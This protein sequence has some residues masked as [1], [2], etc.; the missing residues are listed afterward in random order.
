MV[1]CRV[2]AV[3]EPAAPPSP[4][5]ASDDRWRALHDEARALA[6]TSAPE[7]VLRAREAVGVAASTGNRV[8]EGRSLLLLG[9]TEHALGRAEEAITCLRRARALFAAAGEATYESRALRELGIVHDGLG[10]FD[11]ALACYLE[12]RTLA[13]G[14]GDGSTEAGLLNS[15][16]VVLSRAGKHEQGLEF[17]REAAALHVREGSDAGLAPVLNNIGIN[18]RHLGRLSEAREALEQVLDWF[19][20]PDQQGSRAAPLLNLARVHAVA[21]DEAAAEAAFREGL[22]L[23]DARHAGVTNVEADGL[24]GLG[25]LLTGAGRLDEARPLL[26]RALELTQERG[27]AAQELECHLALSRLHERAGDFA[28]ALR[29]HV[30]YHEI[31]RRLFNEKS[32]V[33]MRSLQIRH[34]VAELER[35]TLEDGLTGL[36]NRRLLDRQ[37]KSDLARSRKAGRSLV[38]AL[39]DL[40]DFKAVNDGFSHVTGDDVLRAMARLLRDACRDTDLVARF[41]GEEF[42][43]LMPDTDGDEAS[44][45]LED[46]RR[47][48]ESHAWSSIHPGL[49]VT[50]SIGWAVARVSPAEPTER[51]SASPDDE[52]S[53]LRRAD[54]QL[55]AAKRAGK[56]RVHG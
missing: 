45:A 39:C 22:A 15:I 16:G 13:S 8:A 29:H 56:N 26:E 31:D 20:A 49:R 14:S 33:K 21:G 34:R 42:A 6:D 38:L 18:L 27:W 36:A 19:S 54:E 53:L 55:Y 50:I 1:G 3:I 41:G 10:D 43:V 24:Q 48:V 46:V 5:G 35:Q 28:A 44:R 40:D 51:A 47:A 25:E 30:A 9:P 12:S 17:F 23:K 11:E 32:D 7:A 4:G 2:P 37:L 52:A